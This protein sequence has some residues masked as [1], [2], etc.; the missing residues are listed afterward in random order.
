[1]LN[2]R[3]LTFMDEVIRHLNPLDNIRKLSNTPVLVVNGEW[4]NI[5]P[6]WQAQDLYDRAPGP[7]Q[8]ALLPRR[9]HFTIMGSQ[10]AINSVTNWFRKWL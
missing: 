9:N 5:T 6:A 8:L 10:S 3:T 1:M 4:D 2:P 7:R